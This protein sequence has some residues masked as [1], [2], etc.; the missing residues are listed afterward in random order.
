[1]V[2]LYIVAFCYIT[3]GITWVFY[4]A[5]MKL[6]DKRDYLKT[7]GRDFSIS[8]KIWGIP[9][10]FIGLLIDVFLNLTV[11]SLTF[12]EIPKYTKKEWLF[13]GRVS[14]WNDSSTWRGDLARW[15]CSEFLD[16]FEEG[17]HCS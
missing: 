8:Q 14:R 17:G 16:P 15:Y 13:T 9:I 3:L 10:I 6:K 11:G 5:A 2:I 12:F 1:M 7:V 4:L